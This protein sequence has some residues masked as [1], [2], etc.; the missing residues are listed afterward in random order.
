MPDA[1]AWIHT[2]GHQKKRSWT[3]WKLQTWSWATKLGLNLIYFYWFDLDDQGTVEGCRLFIVIWNMHLSPV[4]QWSWARLWGKLIHQTQWSCVTL[5]WTSISTTLISF[6]YYEQFPREA[7][8]NGEM[9]T[10]ACNFGGFKSMLTLLH[11]CRGLYGAEQSCS[12][13]NC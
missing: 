3:E 5:R 13:H 4:S 1:G 11:W 7:T 9:L 2:A 6:S 10:S 12:P 8:P